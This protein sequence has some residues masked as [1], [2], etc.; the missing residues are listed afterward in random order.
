MKWGLILSFT[1][2]SASLVTQVW[3]SGSCLELFQST[4]LELT[5]DAPPSE[6]QKEAIRWDLRIES[7]SG[8]DAYDSGEVISSPFEENLK[9]NFLA[10]S[11][12]EN[13]EVRLEAIQDFLFLMEELDSEVIQRTVQLLADPVV[14]VRVHA[15]EF[16]LLHP[17]FG[18]S[19]FRSVHGRWLQK[20]SR[21]GVTKKSIIKEPLDPTQLRGVVLEAKHRHVENQLLAVPQS[22]REQ[23]SQISDH[24]VTLAG[25]KGKSLVL[26]NRLI[27]MDPEFRMISDVILS[28]NLDMNTLEPSQVS[29]IIYSLVKG[30]SHPYSREIRSTSQKLLVSL[31]LMSR[32]EASAFRLIGLMQ[33]TSARPLTSSSRRIIGYQLLKRAKHLSG[34]AFE[35]LLLGIIGEQYDFNIWTRGIIESAVI[36]Q[37]RRHQDPAMLA[38]V[39]LQAFKT[40]GP[41]MGSQTSVL[42]EFRGRLQDMSSDDLSDIQQEIEAQGFYSKFVLGSY[43][44]DGSIDSMK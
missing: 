23:Y 19:V 5:E 13:S 43:F 37:V 9:W 11:F 6:A 4:P 25:E 21:N 32:V 14:E 28:S 29:R 12:D 1:L 20:P 3:A 38:K 15:F 16:L 24:A 40:Y 27:D 17:D 39:Y 7:L 41:E 34:A 30:V 8:G 44:R 10:R 42:M 26:T 35:G 18:E 33:K 2:F 22:L 36:R 31:G